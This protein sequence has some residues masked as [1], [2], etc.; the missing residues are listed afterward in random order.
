ME[1]YRV[2]EKN[3]IVFSAF[4]NY[5]SVEVSLLVGRSLKADV[6]LI[7]V[8]D[9]DQLVMTYVVTKSFM[10][11]VVVVYRPNCDA[12]KRSFFWQLRPFLTGPELMVLVGHWNVI[13]DSELERVGWVAGDQ[14][15]MSNQSDGR[16]R[17]SSG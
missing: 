12:D 7:F 2:L 8:D 17:L 6:N 1:D 9:E 14:R 16:A 15:A 11:Q 5:N 3:Y 4:A 10:L 13:L